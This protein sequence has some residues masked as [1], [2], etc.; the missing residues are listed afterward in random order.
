M[1]AVASAEAATPCASSFSS[2]A[3]GRL[4][5]PPGGWQ[6]CQQQARQCC[7]QLSFACAYCSR[8]PSS[9]QFVASTGLAL[10]SHSTA[11]AQ[12]STNCLWCGLQRQLKAAVE[13]Y[14][15]EGAQPT[16]RMIRD[17]AAC[18]HAYIN[19]DHPSF[20]GGN[21]AVALVSRVDL[22]GGNATQAPGCCGQAA[23]S[24]AP[25]AWS[26]PW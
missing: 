14:I 16:V 11:I 25:L 18:E 1:T 17:F 13:D 10:H 6:L 23:A 21:R 12:Q 9:H 4:R 19:T 22:P 24:A 20:I 26:L 15:H 3:T 2:S 5:Q 8:H 7:W